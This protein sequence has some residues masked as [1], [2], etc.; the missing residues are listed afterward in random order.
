MIYRLI[1]V[2][3]NLSNPSCYLE[4]PTIKT[5]LVIGSNLG[6]SNEQFS[7]IF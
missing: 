5:D 1:N 6:L 7:N 2:N 4:M 3:F